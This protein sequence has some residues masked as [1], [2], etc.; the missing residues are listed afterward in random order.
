[1]LKQAGAVATVVSSALIILAACSHDTALENDN[2]ETPIDVVE[3]IPRV[4]TIGAISR[5]SQAL[6]QIIPTDA[7]VEVLAKGFTWPEGPVWVEEDN[8][9]YFDDVPENKMYKWTEADGASVFL[10]PSGGG[11]EAAKSMREP[12]ANGLIKAPGKPGHLLLA[13]HGARG[14]SLLNL[15]SQSRETLVSQYEG[16][17]LNS[18]NDM[19]ARSDGA[20]FFTDPPY[21]LRGLNA[22]PKKQLTWNGVYLFAANESLKLLIDDLTFPNG[23]A[24]SPD[25]STLYVAVSDPDNPVILS[26]TF[27][28]DGSVAAARTLFDG[29]PYLKDNNGLPDGMVVA[30]NGT[31]FATAPGGV[32]VLHPADGKV[33]GILSTGMPA[34][35]CTLDDNE[36]Y[37]YITS[38]SVLARVPVNFR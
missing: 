26:Y 20:V 29:R 17:S 33:L 30:K 19:I 3:D 31:I 36:E 5:T 7:R 16:Q 11:G 21:G 25:E 10:T 8:A 28:D 4:E 22:S 9:L 6:D 14:L 32:Y 23:I 12:G 18:P 37:L 34:S 35:N 2:S 13:D 38:S 1:M 27:E 24:L 15:E